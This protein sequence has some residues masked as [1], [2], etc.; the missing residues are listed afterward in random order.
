MTH[1]LLRMNRFFRRVS[2]LSAGGLHRVFVVRISKILNYFF[3]KIGINVLPKD[4]HSPLPDLNEINKKYFGKNPKPYNYKNLNLDLVEQEKLLRNFCDTCIFEPYKNNGLSLFDSFL[5][6][7]FIATKKPG[8]VYEIGCG[9]T[10]KIIQKAI[11]DKCL[12]TDHFCIEPYPSP[13]LYKLM[14]DDANSIK[15]IKNKVQDLDPKIF[16]DCDFLFI[17]SSHVVKTESDVLFELLEIIPRLKKGSIVHFHDIVIPYM[18]YL[19][20]HKNPLMC[21][22]ESYFLHAFLTFNNEW[23]TIFSSRFFQQE[24]YH[25]LKKY[26]PYL[27]PN[28]RNTSYYIQST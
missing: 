14:D 18:Y 20:W 21:W 10:T 13:F 17:D 19:D 28:H 6:Y 11:K 8:K 25:T 4:F 2:S 15:L 26:A 5:L 16:D 9:H 22:N 12:S 27:K 23:K 1:P 24:K 7:S 3:D